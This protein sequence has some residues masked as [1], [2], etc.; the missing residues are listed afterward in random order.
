MIISVLEPDMIELWPKVAPVLER[1]AVL[2]G[3]PVID[4]DEIV[5]FAVDGDEIIGAATTRLTSDDYGEVVLIGGTRYKEWVPA[6]EEKI[7]DWMRREGMKE[8]RGHGRAGWDRVL[9]DYQILGREGEVI[10]FGKRL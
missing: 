5:W 6:M 8:I 9:K 1:A 2:S 3:Q 7:S 10:S 4:E